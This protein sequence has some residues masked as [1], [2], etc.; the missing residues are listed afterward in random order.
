MAMMHAYEPSGGGD[1][2]SEVTAGIGSFESVQADVVEADSLQPRGSDFALPVTR[3]LT[4]TAGRDASIVADDDLLLQGDEVAIVGSKIA[5]NGPLDVQGNRVGLIATGTVSA[6]SQ[7]DIT[8][9]TGALQYEIMLTLPTASVANDL[10][11][12]LLDDDGVPD[13]STVYD[14]QFV[15]GAEATAAANTRRGNDRWLNML[16]AGRTDKTMRLTLLNLNAVERT[17]G[18]VQAASWD[19]SSLFSMAFVGLRHRT[20]AA[21]SGIRVIA[22]TGTVTGRYEVRAV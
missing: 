1:P 10:S 12:Q 15:Q 6:Q 8:G 5:L 2:V 7:F 17:I 13:L 20:A 18:M 14:V 3:D 22:S 9:L 19:A 4:V 11:I 21:F 16:A